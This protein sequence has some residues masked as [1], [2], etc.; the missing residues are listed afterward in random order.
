MKIMET[1]Q[2]NTVEILD[3]NEFLKQNT[4]LSEDITTIKCEQY[5]SVD[6]LNSLIKNPNI[7]CIMST[8]GGMNSNSLLPYIDYEFFKK[9]PKIEIKE[10]KIQTVYLD[11]NSSYTSIETTIPEADYAVKISGQSMEPTIQDGD[12]VFVKTTDELEHRNIGIFL[13]DGN[14][15]C[16]RFVKRGKGTFL[17]PDNNSGEYEEINLNRIDSY[18][19]L[20]KVI[21][22]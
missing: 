19:L 6:Q 22:K 3:I 16:K 2:F 13:V 4:L 15:M 21:S 9:N 17:V 12:V 11:E 10:I 5:L 7:K 8:I 18:K 20:G 14:V 1:K